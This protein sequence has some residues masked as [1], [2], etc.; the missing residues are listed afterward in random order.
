MPNVRI[1][2][3]RTKGWRKPPG[4]MIVDRTSDFGNPFTVAQLVDIGYAEPQAR[5]MVIT[6]FRSWL[7]GSRANWAADEADQRRE[8]LLTRMPELHGMDL[9]CP[10]EEGEACHGDVLL[11]WGALPLVALEVRIASARAR[12]DRQR[13]FQGM[14]PLHDA[15]AL[16]AVLTRDV[17][18]RLLVDVDLGD[19]IPQR[20]DSGTWSQYLVSQRRA[21]EPVTA[22]L[23]EVFA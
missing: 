9:A 21:E 3:E 17:G 8:K 13:A 14:K 20:W 12:V 4:C 18:P 5:T 6:E 11:E 16:T 15:A 7:R 19:G 10:C 23:V 2:R 22:R 1:K